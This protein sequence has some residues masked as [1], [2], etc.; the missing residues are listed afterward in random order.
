MGEADKKAIFKARKWK[1]SIGNSK[2]V[3]LYREI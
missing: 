1:E 3:K 2:K